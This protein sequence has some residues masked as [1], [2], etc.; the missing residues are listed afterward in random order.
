MIVWI[1]LGKMISLLGELCY[2]V[3]LDFT[4]SSTNCFFWSLFIAW[5]LISVFFGVTET[6]TPIPWNT[7][8]HPRLLLWSTLPTLHW[9]KEQF[10][11]FDKSIKWLF[12]DRTDCLYNLTLSDVT[13]KPRL[14]KWSINHFDPKAWSSST[15]NP[16]R[17]GVRKVLVDDFM[18]A[19]PMLCTFTSD[20]IKTRNSFWRLF[21]IQF[22]CSNAVYTWIVFN[23][24]NLFPDF[25]FD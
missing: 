17:I 3:P 1:E 24:V 22:F 12:D 8:F 20:R 23:Y 19:W 16:K 5:D 4:I 2:S 14:T 25:C 13:E 10:E 21:G 9:A 6:I 18:I 15:P 7:F 11:K